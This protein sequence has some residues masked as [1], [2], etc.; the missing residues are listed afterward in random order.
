MNTTMASWYNLKDTLLQLSQRYE[1]VF[2][3]DTDTLLL[4]NS[5][6]SGE[7]AIS[8]IKKSLMSGIPI[9]YDSIPDSEDL[10]EQEAVPRRSA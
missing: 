5:G 1:D 6:I 9:D 7:D 2:G 3:D 10:E 4:F 8:L